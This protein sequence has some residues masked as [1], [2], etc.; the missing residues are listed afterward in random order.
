[1]DLLFFVASKNRGE[2]KKMAFI[3]ATKFREW[4]IFFLCPPLFPS[5]RDEKGKK[6]NFYIIEWVSWIKFI[7]V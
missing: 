6:K 5:P 2:G 3:N 7:V 1:M 4:M